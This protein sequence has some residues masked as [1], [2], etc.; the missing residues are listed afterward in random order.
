MGGGRPTCSCGASG[1]VRRE[2]AGRLL[3]GQVPA[4]DG[5]LEGGGFG[6][7]EAEVLRGELLGEELKCLYGAWP[8]RGKL[9]CLV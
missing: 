4:G 6:V 5:Q 1:A 9:L 7:D 8:V 3:D 2:D